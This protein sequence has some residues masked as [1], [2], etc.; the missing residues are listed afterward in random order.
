MKLTFVTFILFLSMPVLAEQSPNSILDSLL[1][2]CMNQRTNVCESAL[3][4][5]SD[6]KKIILSFLKAMKSSLAFQ[7]LYIKTYGKEKYAELIDTYSLT[8]SLIK[9]SDYYLRNKNDY[10]ATFQ[11]PDNTVLSILK[12]PNGWVIDLDNSTFSGIGES[13]DL[14]M[15]EFVD[16]LSKAHTHLIRLIK[17]NHSAKEI[18]EKGGLYYLAA[19]YSLLPKEQQTRL[20]GIFK[21]FDSDVVSV[22]NELVKVINN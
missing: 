12:S 14:S 8:I 1:G 21:E 13:N 22:K 5:D 2:K 20:D 19:I 16:L 11:G 10:S 9:S 6:K 7:K 18:Y 15:I 17:S 3:V 4:G